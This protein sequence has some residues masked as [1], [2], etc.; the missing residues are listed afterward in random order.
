MAFEICYW[1]FE[2]HSMLSN[3]KKSVEHI[4]EPFIK[5]LS[6]VNPNVLTLLGSIPSLLFFVFVINHWYIWALI[7]FIGSA[8]DLIDGMVA[9]KYNKVTTFGAFLDS[10]LDRV[11][12]FLIISSFAFA[13]IVRLEIVAP[14]LLF[15]FMISYTRSRSETLTKDKTVSFAVGIMERTERLLLT[16]MALL[17]YILLP[18]FSIFNLNIA[19]LIFLIVG[20]L[21]F[22][23]VVQRITYAYKKL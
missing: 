20:I 3:Q 23:T 1:K 6:G 10:T 16:I 4:L 12:D 13:G 8:F 21:S 2:I 17:L 19:E 11:S 15:S 7:A 22:F 18:D 5:P 14:V 9:R